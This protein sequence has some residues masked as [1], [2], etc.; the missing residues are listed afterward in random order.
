MADQ[1]R[2]TVAWG[3]GL[4]LYRRGERV[5][6]GHGGAMPGFLAS[7]VVSRPDAA[8]AVVLTGSGAQVKVE[9]LALELAETLL[10]AGSLDD[11]EWAPDGGAPAAVREVL[12][13]WWTEGYE[14]VVSWRDGTL[15]SELVGAADWNRGSVFEA[16]GEDRWRCVEGRERGELLRVVRNE[17]GEVVKLYFATYPCTREPSTFG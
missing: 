4:G 15:R 6:A 12:G 10:E 17:R 3:L 2:W 13:R 9:T 8:G 5:Y 1:E 7:L 11:R 16:E 14:L